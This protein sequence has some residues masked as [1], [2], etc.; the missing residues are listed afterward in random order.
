MPAFLKNIGT[1]EILIIAL[2]LILL[3]GGKKFSELARG[4]GESKH[5]A[6][7]IKE[8]ITGKSKK[9]SKEDAS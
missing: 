5:E 3:F 2:V 6:K 9:E 1:V 8:E 7:K 4:L